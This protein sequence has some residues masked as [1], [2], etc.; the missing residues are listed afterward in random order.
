MDRDRNYYYL[1]K[2]GDLEGLRAAFRENPDPCEA[3]PYGQSLAQLAAFEGDVEILE[4]LI[5][6][7]CDLNRGDDDGWTP[8]HAAAFKNNLTAAELLLA[9]NAQV[10]AQ[11]KS[12]ATPLFRAVFEFRGDLSMISLLLKYG[13]DP[14]HEDSSGTSPYGFAEKAGMRAVVRLFCDRGFGGR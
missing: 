6:H 13:A 14:L 12:G 1:I 9:A 8:L 10:D 5:S 2:R 7:G 11:D 3:M 4:F